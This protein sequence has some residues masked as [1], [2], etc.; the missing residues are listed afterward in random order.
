MLL[1]EL[2]YVQ[3]RGLVKALFL[4]FYR[5]PKLSGSIVQTQR[6]SQRTV[7]PR[8]LTLNAFALDLRERLNSVRHESTFVHYVLTSQRVMFSCEIWFGV[9][10]ML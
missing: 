8:K 6:R 5:V 2:V 3:R 1:F 4:N 10:P 9:A 7:L